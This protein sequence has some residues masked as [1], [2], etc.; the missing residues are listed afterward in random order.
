M[1][2][3]IVCLLLAALLLTA[4]CA[5]TAEEATADAANWYEIFVYSFQDSDGNGIGDLNGVR[6]RLDYVEELGFDGIWLM[7]IMPSPSYHKYDVTDYRAVDPLYGTVGDLKALAADCHARGI[8]LIIDLVVNH[9]SSQHPW[10]LEA[11]DALRRGETDNPY[12]GYYCFS[13]QPGG[14]TAPVSGTDWYYEEQFS[15]G[16]M[17]DLNLS[18]PAV[19]E[20]IRAIM[21]FWLTECEVDGFRLDAV[22][23]YFAGDVP[24]NVECLRQLKDMAEAI[25]PG[26]YLVGEAWTSLNEIAQYYES[27]ID[28]FFLFPASQAE[29]YIAQTVRSQKPASAYAGYLAMVEDAL[30]ASAVWAP[31]LSNHDTGRAVAA[32]QARQNPAKLKFAHAL[33]NLMGGNAFTY[34]GEE[35][36]MAGSG[37]DPNKR[38]AMHWNDEDM[39]QNPPGVTK[40]EYPYPCVD[41]QLADPDSLVN[42]IRAL[43]QLKKRF[44]AIARGERSTVYADD[45]LC[46]LRRDTQDETVYIAVNFSGAETLTLSLPEE[47]GQAELLDG[48]NASGGAAL[49][50]ADGMTLTLPPYGVAVLQSEG[51]AAF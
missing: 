49:L 8:R 50:D 42:Y 9:T 38:T 22:T 41:E 12:V 44:P 27:G 28:S 33:L 19:M 32:M 5:A 7:P 18:N 11:C 10:F 23:S 15:G 34:Y 1:K 30:P 14:K 29:G 2:K 6:Q 46:L 13:Q 35:I 37:V 36:G 21:D 3:R 48:L 51:E 47:L 4:A 45:F 39:T 25:K 43:N 16:G 20:E 24:A 31:F 17:P 26:S 40:A